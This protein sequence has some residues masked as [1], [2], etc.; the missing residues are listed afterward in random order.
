MQ[1]YEKIEDSRRTIVVLSPDFLKSEW[2]RM[3]FRVAN[4]AALSF[5]GRGRVIIILYG[6]I[7]DVNRLDPEVRAYLKTNTYVKW[8]DP[9][10]YD[11]LRYALPRKRQPLSDVMLV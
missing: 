4:K 10:F 7:G 3:E 2:G 1:I 8:G 9:W 11:K 5:G 6:D